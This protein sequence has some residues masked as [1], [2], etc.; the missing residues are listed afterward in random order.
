MPKNI[1][2]LSVAFGVLWTIITALNVFGWIQDG[3]YGGFGALAYFLYGLFVPVISGII[4][5]AM[6]Q[7]QRARL[8]FLA[9]G[10]TLATLIFGFMLIYVVNQIKGQ[11]LLKEEVRY[12]AEF[13]RELEKANVYR[14][15]NNI[16]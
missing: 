13:Q 12:E 2:I 8:G 6:A 15:Q 5:A 3:F 1:T 9:F 7:E 4:G 14:K 16:Q 11:K 10:I